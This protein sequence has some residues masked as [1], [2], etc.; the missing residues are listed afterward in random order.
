MWIEALDISSTCYQS[1]DDIC[2]MRF[3]IETTQITT[4]MTHKITNK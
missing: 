4:I 2:W 3:S 1:D